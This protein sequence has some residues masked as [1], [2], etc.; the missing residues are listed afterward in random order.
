VGEENDI[1]VPLS[2]DT[3]SRTGSVRDRIY[4]YAVYIPY[5][6][7]HYTVR[8]VTAAYSIR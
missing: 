1:L 8:P 3:S 2:V 6:Y 4:A 7:V 5:A